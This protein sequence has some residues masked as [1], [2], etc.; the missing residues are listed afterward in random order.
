LV[1]ALDGAEI[2]PL[3]E[4]GESAGHA[5]I[6]AA[7]LGAACPG[8]TGGDA[9]A[10]TV[11]QRDTRLLV[12]RELTFGSR[13]EGCVEC[14]SCGEQLELA[15]ETHPFADIELADAVDGVG[16]LVVDGFEVRFRAVR[17]GDLEAAAICHD[18]GEARE[19]LAVRCIIEATQGDVPVPR[20][21]LPDEI[22]AALAER[23]SEADPH[24]ELRVALSCAACEHEWHA[25]LDVVSFLWAEVRHEAH[26]LLYEVHTLARSYGWREADVLGLSP[27]R[28]AHY[29]ELAG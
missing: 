14:P 15:L 12:L 29:L 22:I 9:K 28:R 20:D 5:G 26:R 23:L 3:W 10:L 16:I 19:Q 27:A 17:C 11:G 25:L 8:L 21:E 18:T 2:V 7:L 1:R 24:A 6:G 4:A 13:L